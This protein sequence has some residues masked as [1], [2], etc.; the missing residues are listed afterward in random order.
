MLANMPWWV[1]VPLAKKRSN[2]SP[3]PARRSK[4]GVMPSALPSAPT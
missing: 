1:W 3:S 2:N 4:F